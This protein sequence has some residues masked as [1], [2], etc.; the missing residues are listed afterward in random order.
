MFTINRENLKKSHQTIW[1]VI[2]FVML[3]LLILNLTLIIFDSI[4][5][6]EAIQDFFRQSLPAFYSFYQPIHRNFIFYDLIFVSIFLTEFALRWAYAVWHGIYQRWYFYPFIH[7]YDLL[8]CI[9]TSGMRF[10]RVLR[11]VSIV[12]RL[13]RYGVIDF[14][15]TRLYRFLAFYYDA[16]ME[17][18]SDRIVLKVLS[19]VQDEV[20]RGSPLLEKVHDNIIYPR[21]DILT[22]WISDRVADLASQGYVPNR[23]ALRQYLEECINQ[24]IR[25]NP[26]ISRLKLLPIFG[27]Q[28]RGTLEEA[29]GDITAN[30]INQ[31]MDDLSSS[32]N[33]DFIN[34]LVDVF[35][36]DRQKKLVHKGTEDTE[37]AHRQDNEVLINL[38]IEIIDAIKDQV[39]HKRWR[40]HL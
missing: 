1:F 17:E 15:H 39:H 34:D 31:V 6:F 21:K 19:G 28:V 25:Q 24:A 23:G 4:Y 30:V 13:H 40:E 8:G 9:P 33:H 11:V 29:I 2:D 10:L 32:R 26:E 37:V 12:Y 16:F 36:P 35:L 18:L 22:G 20:R 3:G 14:T 38:T 27:N 7:W 5:Y